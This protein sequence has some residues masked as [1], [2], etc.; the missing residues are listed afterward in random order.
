MHAGMS[1][2]RRPDDDVVKIHGYRSAESVLR[3]RTQDI[4]RAYFDEQRRREFGDM[5]RALAERRVAYRLLPA[6]ELTR[7]SA[8]QHH[9]GVCLLVRPRAPPSL[10]DWIADLPAAGVVLALDGV[11]NPHNLGAII[12]SAAHFGAKGVLVVGTPP[13]HGAL[14][15]VAEGATEAVDVLPTSNLGAAVPRL[16]K[17][18]FSVVA[19]DQRAEGSLFEHRFSR[20]TLIVLGSEQEGL[21]REVQSLAEVS[22]SVPGTGVVESLNVA[23]TAAVVLAE[24]ARQR[25]EK[26]RAAGR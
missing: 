20:R 25:A 11:K 10:D 24:Y 21:S 1:P 9:E 5:M 15:R 14:V 19:A 23:S 22:L 8:S 6:E 18:G 13:S 17:V 4:V 2:S 12:R 3:H 16:V 7:V 26:R